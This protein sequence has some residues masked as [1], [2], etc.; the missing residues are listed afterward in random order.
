MM[1]DIQGWGGN[2]P[3]CLYG[4]LGR[5]FQVEEKNLYLIP[6]STSGNV[7]SILRGYR[8]RLF[9]RGEKQK[10]NCFLEVS[11]LTVV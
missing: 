4:I 1:P 11:F 5:D 10:V 2:R 6:Q 7:K 8:K 9:F 3:V